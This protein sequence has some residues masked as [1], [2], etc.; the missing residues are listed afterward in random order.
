MLNMANL[1]QVSS[2]AAA[3]SHNNN[4]ANRAAYKGLKAVA[5]ALHN[6]NQ[7]PIAFMVDKL[8]KRPFYDKRNMPPRVL[9]E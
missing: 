5:V 9:R 1:A 3:A 6:N 2:Q 7:N 8:R 4:Q